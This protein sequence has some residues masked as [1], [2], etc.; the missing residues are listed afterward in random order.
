MAYLEAYGWPGNVRELRN[1]VE[2]ACILGDGLLDVGML[3]VKI[4]ESVGSESVERGSLG[5][6]SYRVRKVVEEQLIRRALKAHGGNRSA[7]ARALRVSRKTLLR[8]LKSFA[9]SV[10]VGKE[11]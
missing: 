7:A 11:T 10:P 2:R 9:E 4:L 6:V 3:P 8:R 1:V 5:D